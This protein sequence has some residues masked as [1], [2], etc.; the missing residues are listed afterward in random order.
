MET[1]RKER[2]SKAAPLLSKAHAHASCSC[3]ILTSKLHQL[4]FHTHSKVSDYHI[5]A[6]PVRRRVPMEGAGMSW[7]RVLGR[8][9]LRDLEFEILTWTR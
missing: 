6:S 5:Y 1:N 8:G 7:E 9:V 3:F 4:P 2:K